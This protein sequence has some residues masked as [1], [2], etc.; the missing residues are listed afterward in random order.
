MYQPWNHSHKPSESSSHSDYAIWISPNIFKKLHL[1]IGQVT[2]QI[3]KI[4]WKLCQPWA[5]EVF[6]CTLYNACVCCYMLFIHLHVAYYLP[7]LNLQVSGTCTVA[8]IFSLG[9]TVQN[10]LHCSAVMTSRLV[11]Y[12]TCCFKW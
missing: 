11:K 12:S 7:Y 5:T 4:D 9:L 8:S 2:G 1:P 10:S 6:L 3:N